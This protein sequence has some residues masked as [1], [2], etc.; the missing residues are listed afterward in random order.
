MGKSLLL[1]QFAH[2]VLEILGVEFRLF[3]GHE[4]TTSW[5]IGEVYK[6]YLACGPFTRQ[7]RIVG[8]MSDGRRDRR[9]LLD[10]LSYEVRIGIVGAHGRVNRF[11]DP[12][13]RNICQHLIRRET[14]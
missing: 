12:V 6:V 8:T 14:C 10:R 1:V 3:P 5:K 4:V 11:R 2:E 9:T 7:R 13:D